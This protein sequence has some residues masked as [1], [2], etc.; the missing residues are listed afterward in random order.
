MEMQGLGES[1]HL[2]MTGP[3]QVE[4]EISAAKHYF[5][6]GYHYFLYEEM[7]EGYDKAFQSRIK[8]RD[9]FLELHR[10]GAAGM[11]MVFEEN[12]SHKAQYQV[13][14][15]SMS[16]E[17][18]TNSVRLVQDSHQMSVTARYVLTVN[19]AEL[20]PAVWSMLVTNE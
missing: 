2:K 9:G 19:D 7:L 15:G 3:D 6:N 8:C 20:E 5:K 13:P 4:Q 17:I 1:V 11:D 16:M 10:S 18:C 14:Y 12:K